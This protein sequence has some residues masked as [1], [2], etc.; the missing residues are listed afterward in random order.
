MSQPP[1][2]QVTSNTPPTFTDKD[3][4]RVS[5]SNPNLHSEDRQRPN[6]APMSLPQQHQQR[7]EELKLRESFLQKADQ[8]KYLFSLIVSQTTDFR[9]LQTER[10]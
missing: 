9:L 1:T 4:L 7:I 6:S 5:A 2:P 3:L 8:G 10:L